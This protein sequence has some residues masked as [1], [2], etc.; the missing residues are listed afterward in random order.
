MQSDRKR[1]PSGLKPRIFLRTEL[2]QLK[3]EP[4]EAKIKSALTNQDALGSAALPQVCQTYET[5][6][7][8]DELSGKDHCS[9][10]G[11]RARVTSGWLL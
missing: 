7:R 1:T 4:T 8:A 5:E 3:L 6:C 2:S 9:N 11:W 10:R